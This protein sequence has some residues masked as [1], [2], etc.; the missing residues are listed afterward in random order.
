VAKQ[1]KKNVPLVDIIVENKYYAYYDETD[2]KIVSVSNQVLQQY[3]HVIEIS[4]EEY[5]KLVSGVHK[6]I[7]YHVGVV[8]DSEGNPVKGLVPNQII[9]E[10]SFKNRLLAWID[11][12]QNFADIEI[13]WDEYNS[14]WIFVASNDL[15]QQ[16]YD[17]KLTSTG[18]SF[19]IT[20]GQDPNFLLRTIDIDFK[21]IITDKVIVKFEL[22]YEK[23]IKDIAITS[24]LAML[25]YSLKVWSTVIE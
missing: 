1:R 20:L 9:V 10:N 12:E 2:N 22:T 23:N 3:T 16:Y 18:V 8:I 24:N 19:F 5:S 17:N 15:R 13:H 7:D 11:S 25:D 14:Q 4:F 21:T 6:F